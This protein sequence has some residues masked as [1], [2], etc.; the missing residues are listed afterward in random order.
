MQRADELVMKRPISEARIT[1]RSDGLKSILFH[2]HED[3]GLQDRLQ[4]A[5]AL[6]R[7][8]SAHIELIQVIPIEAYTVVDAYASY[9]SPQ[10]VQAL[11][12]EAAKVRASLEAQLSKEDV[13]WS[14]EVVS[15]S[16]IPALIKNAAL[17]DLLFIDRQPPTYELGRSALSL[18]GELV[19]A[20][21]TP[22]CLPGDASGELDP[23]GTAVIAWNGSIEAANAVR[24]SIGMLRMAS[25]VRVVRFTENQDVTFPDTRLVEYL[26]R[27]GVSAELDVRAVRNDYVDDL[28]EYARVYSAQYV[29]MGGYSHSRA[30]E[31]LFGGV[32]RAFLH[33]CPVTLVLAH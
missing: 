28:V 27:H 7:A 21:R 8:C 16:F 31:F 1:P 32:T 33:A 4:A 9:V 5:L 12:E 15:S 22:L 25:R 29:V 18:L 10:I 26:S 11:E 13:S 19:C 3:D 6:A 17:A 24:G 23:F 14:F 2:V 20:A 30:G